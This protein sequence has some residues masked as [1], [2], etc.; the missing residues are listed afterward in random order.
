MKKIIAYIEILMIIMI[1]GCA[2]SNISETNDSTDVEST[3][4]I[5]LDESLDVTY[6]DLQ[7]LYITFPT[8]GNLAETL[9]FLENYG[10]PYSNEKYNGSRAI[11]VSI[12]EDGTVQKYNKSDMPY[13]TIG[14]NYEEHNNSNDDL[15]KYSFE[16]I[17]YVPNEGYFSFGELKDGTGFIRRLGIDINLELSREDQIKFFYQ[18]KDDKESFK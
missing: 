5:R 4:N 6:D 10:L 18:Y 13:I 3:N 9:I 17:Q 15:S 7:N 16:S 8:D 11:Q 2:E 1:T 12:T 14:Y